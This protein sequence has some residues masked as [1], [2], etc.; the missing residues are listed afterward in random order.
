[1]LPRLRVRHQRKDRTALLPPPRYLVSVQQRR[2]DK[3]HIRHHL[4]VAARTE[5]ARPNVLQ[6]VRNRFPASTVTVHHN[7]S[8]RK[9]SRKV[10]HHRRR[11]VEGE[12][13]A[14][15]SALTAGHN[16]PSQKGYQLLAHRQ[17][18]A[19]ASPAMVGLVKLLEQPIL[20]LGGH[21]DAR[22]THN[23]THLRSRRIPVYGER[24]PA[25]FR[26]LQR[27]PH[28][29]HQYPLKKHRVTQHHRG[30]T[31]SDV[32]QKLRL[33]LHRL[34]FK[35]AKNLNGKLPDAHPPAR[36]LHLR[37]A[38]FAPIQKVVDENMGK[39]QSGPGLL[40]KV[41]AVFL[42]HGSV[43]QNQLQN[44]QRC[45]QRGAN[46]MADGTEVGGVVQRR[47]CP[48]LHVGIRWRACPWVSSQS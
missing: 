40:Q 15:A 23:N 25:L 4:A 36:N 44:G 33:P 17:T 42:R 21:P 30:N 1:M 43:I 11:D 35:D 32:Q 5:H 10:L 26:E 48:E 14:L 28:K 9:P 45:G 24:H 19:C 39:L 34:D 18:K 27:V 37:P 7:R 29:I 22:V 3:N 16:A 47:A 38:H 20:L 46:V 12:P 8:A 31:R 2:H 41:S 6:H 13:R